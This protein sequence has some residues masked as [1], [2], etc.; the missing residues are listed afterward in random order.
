MKVPCFDGHNDTI[1]GLHLEERDGW[2]SLF[3]RRDR[4]HL[5]LPLAPE[6]GVLGGFF[7]HRFLREPDFSVTESRRRHAPHEDG[8]L[9]PAT[10]ERVLPK[11]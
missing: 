3:V 5:D 6:D 2:K 8:G 9:A 11:P 10:G 7:A 1:L 4:G